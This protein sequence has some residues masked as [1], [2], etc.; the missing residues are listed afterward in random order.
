MPDNR[1]RERLM[2][3]MHHMDA[4]GEQ[5]WIKVAT[6]VISDIEEKTRV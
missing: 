5:Q 2:L 3:G 6:S 1:A 4:S